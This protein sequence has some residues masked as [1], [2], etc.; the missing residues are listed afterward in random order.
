MSEDCLRVI[1][2]TAE[3]AQ[4]KKATLHAEGKSAH[5]KARLE[6]VVKGDARAG[7]GGGNPADMIEMRVRINRDLADYANADLYREAGRQLLQSLHHALN[8]R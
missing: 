5:Y 7:L 3:L 4:Q 8:K 2:L 6:A 1:E